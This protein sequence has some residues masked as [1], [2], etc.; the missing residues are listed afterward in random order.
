MAADLSTGKRALLVASKAKWSQVDEQQTPCSTGSSKAGNCK[1]DSVQQWLLSSCQENVTFDSEELVKRQASAEDDLVLGV[2]ASLYGKNSAH[3]T[4]QE[5]LWCQQAVPS[6]SRWNSVTSAQSR[7]LSVMDVLNLWND[8]PEELLL[9][10]GF[11]N[12]EPD[13]SVKIPARFINHQS[14]AHGINIQVF[15]EAQ[16]NRMD[17]ENPDVSN[18][19]K[20]LEVLQQVTSAFSALVTGPPPTAPPAGDCSSASRERR[21][22]LSML[23]R[24]ASKKTLSMNQSQPSPSPSPSGPSSSQGPNAPG[25]LPSDRRSALK[26]SRPGLPENTGLTPLAEEQSPNASRDTC[27]PPAGPPPPPGGEPQAAAWKGPPL[28]DPRCPTQEEEPRGTEDPR[29]IHSFDEGSVAGSAAGPAESLDTRLMRTSS[30]QSDSSG[31]L[32]EPVI[33]CLSQ[34]TTPVPE[35]MKALHAISKD[36]TD[37]QINDSSILPCSTHSQRSWT[38]SLDLPCSSSEGQ[39]G[40]PESPRTPCQA[41][42]GTPETEGAEVSRNPALPLRDEGEGPLGVRGEG[43]DHSTAQGGASNAEI[44][45]GAP[46]G[47]QEFVSSLPTDGNDSLLPQEGAVTQTGVLQAPRGQ[48]ADS[49]TGRGWREDLPD[50]DLVLGQGASEGSESEGSM[51]GVDAS[52]QGWASFGSTKSVSVQL[53]SSLPSMSQTTRRRRRPAPPLDLR[54]EI[55]DATAMTMSQGRGRRRSRM[56]TASLDTGLTREEEHEEEEA[57][58]EEEVGR[59][60]HRVQC[61][62]ACDHRCTCCSQHTHTP[63]GEQHS[64]AMKILHHAASHSATFPYSLDELEGMMRCM[65]KFRRVLEE[66]EERLQEEQAQ[67]YNVFSDLDREDMASIQELRTAVKK[68]AEQLEMQLTDLAHHYDTGIKTKLHRLLDEQ[69]H[70]CTQLRIH[71]FDAPHLGPTHSLEAT[72]TGP[73]SPAPG[74]MSSRSVATQCCLLP[75]LLVNDATVPRGVLGMQRFSP[76]PG[77]VLTRARVGT[78]LSPPDKQDLLDFVGFFQSVS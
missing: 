65:R 30:C 34:Q 19:F 10:L 18:R 12:E 16:K 70:L 23:F 74:S 7:T 67:V 71:P 35:L 20:E 9:E 27:N 14:K 31:F 76:P 73:A 49:E 17:L 29:I 40:A 63:A 21:K 66:I 75:D 47:E 77:G 28:R 59:W 26:R 1:E 54:R 62:C 53:L 15:L 24:R 4:V 44:G 64:T 38:E 78:Q 25:P 37:S 39:Q 22:R 58:G 11:G 46:T 43:Q 13:I 60:E 2:E 51:E 69:S 32:E 6:L 61:C 68:E 72:T 55:A 52:R 36:S 50:A 57:G 33:P 41:T 48:S 3:K 8:D 56:R 5:F 42:D 45:E